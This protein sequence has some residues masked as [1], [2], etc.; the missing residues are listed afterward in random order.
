MRDESRLKSPEHRQVRSFLRAGGL[1]LAAIGLVMTAIGMTSFFL[2]FGGYGPPKYFFLALIGL[3]MLGIGLGMAQFGFLGA[4]T[5]YQAG[6]IAPVGKDTFNY[7]ADGTGSGVKTMA[8][9]AGEGISEGMAKGGPRVAC[10]ECRTP[11]DADARFCD[12]CGARMSTER[13]CPECSNVN[14]ADAR[15]CDGCGQAL[16]G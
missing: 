4:I 6:E 15:F 3:P 12:H 13:I 5:R 16:T 1:T 8:T 7:L 2:A 10:P 9:A 14:D 11:N